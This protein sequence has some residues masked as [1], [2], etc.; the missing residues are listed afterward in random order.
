[1]SA[2]A[3][4]VLFA[5]PV[6]AQTDTIA[7]G[8]TLVTDGIPRMP[9]ALVADVRRYTESRSALLADWHPTRRELLIATRFGNSNQIHSVKVP[10]GARTQLTFADEPITFARY[11]PSEGSYFL[12]MKDTGGNE[13]S[14][15]YRYDVHT[16]AITLL[17]DGGRSQTH[18][19][20]W[21]RRGDLVAYDSTRRN[22]ADR[23]VYVMNPSDGKTDRLVLQVSGGGWGVLDWSPDD[24]KLLVQEYLSVGRS[25]LWIV[26]VASGQ[27]TGLTPPHEEVA[28]R[29]GL[30]TRDGR[31]A[32]V[33][34]DKDSEFLRLAYIDLATKQVTPLTTDLA[35]DIT[36]IDLSH[37]GRTLAFVSNE[38][39]ISKL[40]LLDTASRRYRPVTGLPTGAIA[41]LLWHPS[42]NE[43]AFTVNSARSASDV[44]SLTPE[45][46]H[47]VRWT[48]S[49]LGG[50]LATELSEPEVITWR[51]FDQREITGVYYRP[52]ARF[53]GRRPVIIN[54]HGGPEGQSLPIFIGRSN[55]YLNELGVAIIYPNVRGSVGY[56]KTFHTLDNGMRREDSVKDIGALLDWIAARPDLDAG[57]VMVTGG[58]YGGY[59]T[60]AVATMY[61][62][63]IRCSVDVVGISNFNTFLKN[64]ERYRRDLRR[65]EYGDERQPDIASFF[66][67]IAP[68]NNASRITKP[69]FV[70]QG[71]N[72]PRVPLSESEQMVAR[73]KKNGT[74]VWYL[75]AKDEGHGFAKKGNVDFQFYSTVTFLKTFLLDET[76]P[77]TGAR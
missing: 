49:E 11:Q 59:M 62:D 60:L 31:G 5:A 21:N 33:T 13:F 51:S 28:Y 20:V 16:G 42:T 69:L 35:W 72:D 61:N 1:M 57:R 38:A 30:F 76:R 73:V 77:D 19:M 36:N 25:P 52:P 64:T 7:P 6:F 55:Y 2:A 22:G 68:L 24:A 41:S 15:V 70:V 67:H 75:M 43:L 47:V 9:A 71:G 45:N 40:Y 53:S 58:S 44:Y 63:R 17:T 8:P 74:P 12:F 65:A 27:K 50:L 26:D 10:G 56:G 66:E 3:L 4:W 29:L 37:D 39:G 18:G 32:F 54:I 23:D 48:E 14:Q 34:T 46:G